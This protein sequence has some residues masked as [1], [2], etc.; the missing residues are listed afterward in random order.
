MGA[1]WPSLDEKLLFTYGGELSDSPSVPP[2][3]QATFQFDISRGVWSVAG[4]S[5]V[6][7]RAAEGA[8]AYGSGVGY[9]TS[10]TP[11]D[12]ADMTLGDQILAVILTRTQYA[13]LR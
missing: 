8:S 11:L 7:T 6:V 9:C 13:A 4:T 5:G 12:C 1:L 2:P 10:P 3:A